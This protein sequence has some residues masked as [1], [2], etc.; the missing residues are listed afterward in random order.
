MLKRALFLSFTFLGCCIY[1]NAQTDNYWSWTFNTPSTLLAGAVIGGGAGPSAIY[2]NPALID[3]GNVPSLSLSASLVSLQWYNAENVAGDE[4]D[5]NKF[6]FKIQPRFLSYF[7][8]NK[9]EKI[10][11]EAAILSTIS[12]ELPITVQHYDTLD[13]LEQVSGQEIYTGYINYRKR[14]DD[15]WAGIGLSYQLT[16]KLFIGGSFFMSVK[17]MKYTFSTE[18]SAYQPVDSVFVIDSYEPTFFASN[19]YSEELKYW[20]ISLITK[21]GIQYST[22]DDRIGIGANL[23]FPSINVYGKADVRRSFSRGNIYDSLSNEQTTNLTI[24]DSQEDVKTTVKLPFSTAIGFQYLTA[25]RK[26]LIAISA[27]YFAAIDQ[28]SMLDNDPSAY[29]NIISQQ[30]PFDEDF[31]SFYHS[32]TAVNNVAIGFKQFF[33]E[34]LSLLGGFRTDFSSQ[35]NNDFRLLGENFTINRIRLNKYHVTAGSIVQIKN[36]GVVLGLQYSRGRAKDYQQ[37]INYSD[38]YQYNPITKQGLEGDKQSNVNVRLDE[39]GLYF[40]IKVDFNN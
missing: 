37:I 31:L 30:T 16:P 3:R 5:A 17:T 19:T 15:T 2:Y 12:E 24:T 28:Y 6:I 23:T 29:N 40:G 39:L 1:S 9:N 33:S 32:S 14:Y 34:K 36:F 22:L 11:L 13:I 20:H 25:N 38:P 26:N 7:I 18:A 27:E 8:P 10:G 4:I 21:L 35:P